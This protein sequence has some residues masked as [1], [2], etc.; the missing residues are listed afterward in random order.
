M[1]QVVSIKITDN[2]ATTIGPKLEDIAKFA[3]QASQ[4]LNTLK[5]VLKGFSSVGLKEV[6]ADL[7]GI[8][9]VLKSNNTLSKLTNKSTSDSNLENNRIKQAIA[10]EEQL[11]RGIAN[12]T[13]ENNRLQALKERNIAKLQALK[14]KQQAKEALNSEKLANRII[15]NDNSMILSKQKLFD[16]EEAL[17]IKQAIAYE[18]Q[19]RKEVANENK[20]RE[21]F[22]LQTVSGKPS[23]GF[24]LT[25]VA[26]TIG[27]MW[28]LKSAVEAII[29]PIINLTDSYT[30]LQNK[31]RLVSDNNIQLLAL[32]NQMFDI[33]TRA[34]VPVQDLATAFQRFDL[35][36]KPLGAS[37]VEV[38]AMVETV[39]KAMTLS[40]VST[41]E[42]TQGLRQLSQA[43]NKGKLDGDE[44]RTVMETMPLLAQAIADKLKVAKGELLDLAPK[45]KITSQVMREA[46]KDV[47]IQVEAQFSK[48]IPT[49]EQGLTVVRNSFSKLAGE[50]E[51]STGLFASL[52]TKM[53]NFSKE[54]NVSAPKII[55][56]SNSIL[57]LLSNIKGLLVELSPTTYALKKFGNDSIS[58]IDLI[59]KSLIGFSFTFSAVRDMIKN[60]ID[61]FTVGAKDFKIS[62]TNVDALVNKYTELENTQKTRE[63]TLRSILA[64]DNEIK[65]V[66]NEYAALPN[67]NTEQAERLKMDYQALKNQKATLDGT[68][69]LRAMQEIEINNKKKL[70]A[71]EKKLA[72][73]LER[74]SD[75]LKKINF[76]LNLERKYLFMDDR[77]VS[78]NKRFDR[79]I[80]QYNNA[81]P[82]NKK[83]SKDAVISLKA[84][85]EMIYDE[86][87]LSKL[88]NDI[89]HKIKDNIDEITASEKIVIDLAKSGDQPILLGEAVRFLRELTDSY[90]S[91]TEPLYEFNKQMDLEVKLLK[92]VG[93]YSENRQKQLELEY[94][95]ERKGFE[96]T[97]EMTNKI[98]K[99]LFDNKLLADSQN[100]VNESLEEY[101]KGV[102]KIL[103]LKNLQNNP[104]VNG[105]QR[106]TL[107]M[108]AKNISNLLGNSY[109]SGEGKAYSD[110]GDMQTKIKLTEDMIK[111]LGF[112]I[113]EYNSFK[114]KLT[115]DTLKSTMPDLFP[116]EYFNESKNKWKKYYD[117][118]K[119]MRENN[120]IDAKTEADV[121]F[122]I[123]KKKMEA[124]LQFT[125]NTFSN[126]A[127]LMQ[128]GSRDIFEIGRAFAIAEATI[129][130]YTAVMNAWSEGQKYGAIAAGLAATAA[131]IHAAMLIGKIATSAPP[132]YESGGLIQG[133][134]QTI[135]VNERGR[136][137]IMNA[138]ATS[139]YRPMLESMNSGRSSGVNVKIENYGT[140]KEFEV[141]QLSEY[142]IR[143]IATDEINKKTPDV[144]ASQFR[145]PNSRVSKAINQTLV[146]QRRL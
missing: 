25:D 87:K 19:W 68:S 4:K 44:F 10:Y 31:L 122:F 7:K 64:L 48:S 144:V 76:E 62:T 61:L 138:N 60:A 18:K 55:T 69:S 120:I 97:K 56:L 101:I 46:L 99:R 100:I 136:E 30:Q 41:M 125:Q 141:K 84:E 146:T 13:K 73:Q 89:K 112:S 58:V 124:K 123:E 9:E 1:E 117:Y 3:I 38:L 145:N 17:R 80:E 50:I 53:V 6:F 137:F 114:N 36:L 45:G 81:K 83:M 104:I 2:V 16:K 15:N 78:I 121:T 113:D 59:S 130:G 12:E 102:E 49:I 129:Q 90:L 5:I 131:G 82:K 103:A 127:S 105:E 86:Q 110:I 106:M 28:L 71:E 119:T 135:Q 115:S 21:N 40:G 14:D 42:Q 37:Q 24:D 11:K 77:E 92:E 74:K 132:S 34:R 91:L 35:A 72:S 133:G 47:A 33:S 23:G 26:Y 140:S 98:E 85:L 52:A 108:M 22:R 27:K 96:I 57:E 32:T 67:K 29:R 118:I 65:K 79:M 51:T 143:I 63:A 93:V 139:R 111:N 109:D 107:P 126:M 134:K 66:A 39:S 142:E 70:T 95:L 88:Y 20:R 54:A 94:E 43:F 8:N 116:D 128:S 75:I